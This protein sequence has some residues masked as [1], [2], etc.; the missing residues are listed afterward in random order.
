MGQVRTMVTSSHGDA[1]PTT[2]LFVNGTH[3]PSVTNPLN[4]SIMRSFE[5]AVDQTT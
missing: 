5:H 2:Q 3:P 1:S 4:R